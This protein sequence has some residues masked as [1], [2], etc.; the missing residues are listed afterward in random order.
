[1]VFHQSYFQ[2][3]G[4]LVCPE[5]TKIQGTRTSPLLAAYDARF[6]LFLPAPPIRDL[7]VLP[8]RKHF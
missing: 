2:C 8:I 3:R 1:M 4:G 7:H 6:S 5:E